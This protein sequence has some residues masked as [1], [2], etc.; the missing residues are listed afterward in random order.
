[1]GGWLRLVSCSFVGMGDS[2]LQ[3][4][5]RTRKSEGA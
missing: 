1:V 5:E 2:D 4:L 3:D